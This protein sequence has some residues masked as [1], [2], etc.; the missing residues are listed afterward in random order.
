LAGA[1]D[2]VPAAAQTDLYPVRLADLALRVTGDP[3][4]V[5]AASN[6][7]DRP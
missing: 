3:S 1:L 7:G 6:R 2:Q 5:T 4:G